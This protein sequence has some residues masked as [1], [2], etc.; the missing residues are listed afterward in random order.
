VWA[1]VRNPWFV[2]HYDLPLMLAIIGGDPNRFRPYVDL[3]HRAFAQFGRPVR[4]IE[5]C[6]LT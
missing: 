6:C 4:E 1:A 2:T 5:Q 3:Y